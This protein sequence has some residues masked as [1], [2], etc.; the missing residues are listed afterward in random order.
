MVIKGTRSW[1]SKIFTS[2]LLRDLNPVLSAQ[3]GVTGSRAGNIFKAGDRVVRE[4]H[5]FCLV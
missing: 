5:I 1:S 2:L 4:K 3:S